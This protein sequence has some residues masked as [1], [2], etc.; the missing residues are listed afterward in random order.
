MQRCPSIGSSR[1]TVSQVWVCAAGW[2]E[3]NRCILCLRDIVQADRVNNEGVS[4]A[5]ASGS[6]GTQA[7]AW[8]SLEAGTTTSCSNSSGC[9]NSDVLL[10]PLVASAGADAVRTEQQVRPGN[11]GSNNEGLP[12][13]SGET[14]GKAKQKTKG[15]VATADQ[16]SRAPVGSSNHRIWKCQTEP[17]TGA[18]AKWTREVDR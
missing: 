3:H 7:R 10:R 12:N 11:I 17:L 16:I 15:V 6:D 2:S 18:R 9:S 4:R 13:L 8:C 1:Q 5:I 14:G